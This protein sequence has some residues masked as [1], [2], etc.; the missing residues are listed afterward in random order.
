MHP[1][2]FLSHRLAVVFAL[3]F[4]SSAVAQIDT[5]NLRYDFDANTDQ[6]LSDGWDSLLNG[7]QRPFD[8]TTDTRV[9]T[10]NEAPQTNTT[11]GAIHGLGGYLDFRRQPT[12]TINTADNATANSYGTNISGDPSSAD[13]SFEFWL[14]VDDNSLNQVI[15]ESGGGTDGSSFT[16]SGGNLQW[17]VKDGGT[18]DVVSVPI[19]TGEYH[20]VVGVYDRDAGAGGEDF[21]TLYLDGVATN[22]ANTATDLHDWAGSDATALGGRASAVGGDTGSLGNLGGYTNLDGRISAF[23]FYETALTATDVANSISVAQ[24]PTLYFD[25]GSAASSVWADGQ[26]WDGNVVTSNNQNAVINADQ[27]VLITNNTANV[28]TLFVGADGTSSFTTDGTPPADGDGTV[29]MDGGTLIATQIALGRDGNVGSFTLNDGFI[30]IDH[31]GDAAISGK[32]GFTIGMSASDGDVVNDRSI[33]TMNGGTVTLNGSSDRL[34]IGEDQ[35]GGNPRINATFQMNGG[36]FTVADNIVLGQGGIADN[37]SVILNVAGGELTT[38][39]QLNINDGTAEVNV[40]DGI[41]NITLDLNTMNTTGNTDTYTVS[42]GSMIIGRSMI[43]RVGT[44]QFNLSGG[45]LEFDRSDAPTLE[46]ENLDFSGGTMKFSVQDPATAP[47]PL[48]VGVSGGAGVFTGT[49]TIDVE[50]DNLGGTAA[51]ITT[52]TGSSG[53]WTPTNTTE[54]DAANPIQYIT[55]GSAFDVIKPNA[56]ATVMTDL[57]NI[58]FNPLN[59]DWTTQLGTTFAAG[60]TLQIVA[61][62]DIGMT[63]VKAV[64]DATGNTITRSSDLLVA[65]QVG[66]DAADLDVNNGTLD[67]QGNDLIIGGDV[68]ATV[69]VNAGDVTNVGNIL[70]GNGGSEGGTLTLLGGSTTVTGSIVEGT[71]AAQDSDVNNAQLAID[72]GT[73]S[74]VGNILVQRF[75]IGDNASTTGSYTTFNQFQQV[76]SSGTT[77][78][79]SAGTGTY[80]FGGLSHTANDIRIGEAATGV[81]EFTQTRG[82]VTS[83]S[84]LD[85]GLSGQGTYNL[86][87]GLLEVNGTLDIAAGAGSVGSL[88]IGTLDGSSSGT[89]S[90][91]GGNFESATNGTGTINFYSGTVNQLSN[92]WITGQGVGSAATVQIGGG[93]G[94]ATY[95]GA[96]SSNSFDWN[97]NSGSGTVDVLQN[98]VVNVSRSLNLGSDADANSGLDLD[99][100][101]GAV[102]VGAQSAAGGIDYRANG[103]RDHIRLQSGVLT[104]AQ[105][106]SIADGSGQFTIEGSGNVLTGGGTLTVASGN[107]LNFDLDALGVTPFDIQAEATIAGTINVDDSAIAA[108]AANA[109]TTLGTAGAWDGSDTNW[110]K[111]NPNGTTGF[112]ANDRVVLV[113]SADTNATGAPIDTTGVT[114]IQT[115][116]N[117]ALD[118]SVATEVALVAQN[119]IATGASHAVLDSDGTTTRASDLTVSTTAGSSDAAGLTVTAGDTLDLGGNTLTVTDASIAGEGIFTNGSTVL[120]AGAHVRPGATINGI[121]AGGSALGTLTFDGNVEAQ[122]GSTLH[123]TAVTPTAGGTP[124]ALHDVLGGSG[125]ITLNP[126]ASIVMEWGGAPQ[127]L[128]LDEFKILDFASITDNGFDLGTATDYLAGGAST[129]D[130]TLPELTSFD[131]TWV[132]DVSGFFSTGTVIIVPEP[133]RALLLVVGLGSLFLRR[134]R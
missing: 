37:S 60:D 20:H 116:S 17:I 34:E 26:N 101:G 50:L 113:R 134:R 82:T 25:N 36:S 127:L 5:T 89:I 118:T 84:T 21:I 10:N 3:L 22:G 124:T 114:F 39:S 115:G 38:G 98:G 11:L 55:T 103:P 81:G 32:Q 75:G 47:T 64:I 33:F 90:V 62:N 123:F 45:V 105:N 133:S 8:F 86:I 71:L 9:L 93:S 110:D 18:D 2:T 31:N 57:G 51:T 107:A 67:L 126:G 130:L 78:I 112:A 132:W 43:D 109:P 4:A 122:S 100:R 13:A 27:T 95:G 79:G 53:S 65:A 24:A 61:A 58:T 30:D 48:T 66:G 68:G 108:N 63:P 42:G 72:G 74:V 23:R 104:V 40:S 117:W 106:I 121:V 59:T 96:S 6:L 111:R 80:N 128:R 28:Q 12:S 44:T 56:G 88:T 15:W 35:A 1:N 69:T 120:G 49:G 92:N 97:T 129:G 102:H 94:V 16:V 77:A 14:R 131:P 29:V 99:I 54:W 119:S 76:V 46:V 125:T 7:G 73:L 85:I 83:L 52:W 70:F 41:F 91:N 19:S 87:G